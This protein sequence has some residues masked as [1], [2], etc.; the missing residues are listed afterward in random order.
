MQKAIRAIAV[1][2]VVGLLF[3]LIIYNT[4]HPAQPESTAW[5]EGMTLGKYDE[6]EH[7]FYDYTDIMCPYCDKFALAMDAH[8][9]DFKKEYVE[10]K[11]VYYELRLTNLLSTF[12]P[13]EEGLVANST[14]S[15][16]TGYCASD[17]G[18]FWE[19]YGWILN[20]L[21]DDYFSKGIGDSSTA[22]QRVPKL[23]ASY[24][25]D[26]GDKVEGLDENKL[27]E[28]IETDS[29]KN[30]V[31]KST[32]KATSKIQSG[33]PYYVFDS[34][35]SPGFDGNWEVEHDWK[36]AKTLFEAGLAS[37]KK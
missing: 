13:E 28:C 32:T 8:L 21:N 25:T 7:F 36:S 18:K 11:K 35:V 16:L 17:Q 3:A 29:T 1:L 10:E 37:K 5:D 24:F 30:K 23:E 2:L 31:K 22:K 20:K 27:K 6:A 15:A 26:V 14:N 12:H 19:W 4:T 33:L 34:Y 9:E